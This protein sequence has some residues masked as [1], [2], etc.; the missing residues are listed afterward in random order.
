[1]D[2]DL[3]VGVPRAPSRE[4]PGHGLCVGI[5]GG[6][7]L[8][9]Q[10]PTSSIP[11]PVLAWGPQHPAGEG[12]LRAWAP[13]SVLGQTGL[14]AWGGLRHGPPADTGPL[15]DFRRRQVPPHQV[16]Q[17]VARGPALSLVS[18]LASLWFGPLQTWEVA[19]RTALPP[20]HQRSH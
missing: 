9:S 6:P 19:H 8:P 5:G 7:S 16:R 4:A 17:L 10:L 11:A 3:S 18:L 1:M 12:A 15:R 14:P 2:A 20:P 13:S